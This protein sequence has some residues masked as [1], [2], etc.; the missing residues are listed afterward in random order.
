[1][2]GR[3][4]AVVDT[5]TT[6]IHTGYRH[7]IAEIAIVNVDSNGHITDSW[8]TLVNPER[9]LG[10]QAIHG[11][12]AADAR[13]AP[14]FDQLAAEVVSRLAGRIVVAHNWPFDAMHLRAEFERLDVET[15]F[16][17][18]AGLCTMQAAVRA[19]PGVRRS[20]MECCAAAG[21]AAD[22]A[23]HTAA[24]DATAAAELL[25]VLVQR[26]PHTLALSEEH[27]AAVNWP[28]PTLS[29]TSIARYTAQPPV[30]LPR[31]SWRGSWTGFP[32]RDVLASTPISPCST[33]H[34]STA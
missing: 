19:M 9:D 31:T 15:P 20:L 23:W 33:P 12:R 3:G 10:P 14:R 1:M 30:T 8:D 13:R 22:R 5:E 4:F 26:A 27:L 16:H 24:A 11:I 32:E 21:L 34:Y 17:P 29:H 18:R 6:G 7:R 28:W 2:D 25:G